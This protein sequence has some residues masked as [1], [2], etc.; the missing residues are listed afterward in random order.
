MGFQQ[1]LSGLSAASSNLDVIGNNVANADTV[2]FKSSEAQFADVYAAALTG[3]GASQIGL[4]VKLATVAQQFTQ[5]N[6]TS[7]G[8]SLD[9]AINGEGFY[10]MDNNGSISY[11]RTG[12]FELDANGYIVDATGDKLTGYLP[13]AAGVIVP[14]TPAPL[15]IS[16]AN[17]NPSAT[18]AASLGLNLDAN[19]TPPTTV[20]FSPTDPTSYTSSTSVTIYDSL[21][22]SHVAAM[23]FVNTAP[24][25]WATYMTVDG[26][27]VT[28]LPASLGTLGFNSNGTLT[29]PA[30]PPL[31]QMSASIALTNGAT[32]P[33]T[34]TLDFSQTTQ[35]GASF[36]VNSLTQNGYTS[37][38]LT[39]F[40]TS[41]NGTIMGQYSNGQSKAIG[42]IVLANFANPQGLQA[43]SNNL[44]VQTTASGVPLVG[45]P[46]TSSLGVLQSGATESSNVD[47]TS[48]LVDMIQAQ[49]DYQANAETIKTEDTLMQTLVTLR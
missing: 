47:L 44:W 45:A 24:N 12:Q 3:A 48:Q 19:A 4:G 20:P 10:R 40:S 25:T 33:Q 8:N 11:T 30:G 34:M 42:Q 43:L 46:G 41:S 28:A 17:L 21:G 15:Q 23:Y 2:G 35:Y 5:G 16:T 1:G 7:T 9:I 6:I 37:G 14:S 29:A 13:N 39:A 26:N 22:N 32:T 38:Q 49:R 27:S 31:G 36:G 18:S